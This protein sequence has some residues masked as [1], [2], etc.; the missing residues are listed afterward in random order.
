MASEWMSFE[1]EGDPPAAPAASPW[2]LVVV[3][4]DRAVHDGTRFALQNFALGGRGLEFLGA[5]SGGEGL[6]LLRAHPDAAIVLL[7]VVMETEDAGLKLARA[8]REELGNELVRIILRTGQPGQAPEHHVVVDFDINDY[9]AKTELTADRLFTT[10]T[11]ALRAYEQ[12]KKLDDMRAGLEMIVGASADL[13]SERSLTRL[14]HGVLLQLNALLA[15]Q[16]DGMLVLREEEGAEPTVLA[17]LGSFAA[18]GGGDLAAWMAHAS[19]AGGPVHRNGCVHLYVRTA[20]GA[21]ILV[22]LDTQTELGATQASLVSVYCTKLSAAFDNARMHDELVR[23]KQSLEA[24]V[25]ERTAALRTANERLE[26][27]SGQLKRVNAFK[28]EILG[29]VAHDL[30][31]PLAVILGR[32]EMLGALAAELPDDQRGPLETQTGHLR[33]AARRMT[34]IVDLSVSDAMSDAMDIAINPRLVDLADLVRTVGEMN[35][36]LAAGKSQTLLV[37][38]TDGLHLHCDPDRLGEAVDNLVSNAVKYTPAGGR[39]ELSAG[40]EGDTV[41]VRV[42]DDG[43][44]LR[45][46]DLARLFGRFQRLSA[47]PTGGESSTGLGLSIVRKIV[48]LHEGRIDVLEQGPLGGAAF[49]ISLPLRVSER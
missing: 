12:L 30:K 25:F 15:L 1:S 45:P 28:N 35:A 26:I 19:A 5:Y 36:S 10:I 6:A 17:R 27:Q 7:D 8:I 16:S 2:K 46:E 18:D 3:D 38:A 33:T 34:R 43:P 29:T 31:N 49:T 44:G 22:V 39:I 11:A 48:D 23:A 40:C 14:A 21:E 24:E 20:S 4:D 9:K 47:Q 42:C 32:A 37:S 41:F 13:F